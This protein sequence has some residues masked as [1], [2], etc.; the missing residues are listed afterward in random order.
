MF[1]ENTSTCRHIFLCK[2][3]HPTRGLATALMICWLVAGCTLEEAAAATPREVLPSQ[4]SAYSVGWDYKM[5]ASILTQLRANNREKGDVELRGLLQRVRFAIPIKS[6]VEGFPNAYAFSDDNGDWI[7]IEY[8]WMNQVAGFSD[9]GALYALITFDANFATFAHETS[10]NFCQQYQKT[11]RE[12]ARKGQRSPVYM[13]RFEDFFSR[14]DPNWAVN[15]L[16]FDK[17]AG[18]VWTNTIVWTVLHEVGHHALKHTTTKADSNQ[19]KRQRE[20]EADKW[21]FNRMKTLGYSVFGVGSYFVARG[22]TGLCLGELGLIGDEK[23][24]THP[25]WENRDTALRTNFN[26]L[27]AASQDPRILYIPMGIPEP[28]LTTVVIP[29]SRSH[30]FEAIV[31]QRGKVTIGMTEWD[32]KKAKVFVREA[33]GGRI[34]FIVEDAMRVPLVIEQQLYDDNNHL[35]QSIKMAAVQADIANLDFLEIDGLKFSDIRKRSKGQNLLVVHLRKAGASESAIRKALSAANE[36][37]EYR[38]H[39]GL[40]YVKGNIS[41]ATLSEQIQKKAD[42]Y[43]QH[44]I[45]ILGAN[46]YRAFI[47]SY[48]SE[49]RRIS[50]P[51][52][53]A[54]VWEEQLLKENIKGSGRPP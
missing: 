13:F 49:T 54:D 42:T 22:M 8:H 17:L 14:S 2:L 21:A 34:V 41:Y 37:K 6:V 10:F 23:A 11:Y 45:G 51:M 4:E 1:N 29:D 19:T 28:I 35:V 36:Y 44:L 16:L 12:A 53:G 20:L 46:R 3:T 26:V 31:T 48:V 27:A 7:L 18:L 25:T 43:E 24:S 50:P 9:L 40:E 38:H 52:A 5:V 15:F 39:F 47:D 33:A 30:E 32:G